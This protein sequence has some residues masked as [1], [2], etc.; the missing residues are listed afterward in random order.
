MKNAFIGIAARSLGSIRIG[1]RAL[2]G[3][4]RVVDGL[5]KVA[6]WIGGNRA[7]TSP[8]SG[9]QFE[10]DLTDRI[11]R[12]MWGNIYELHVRECFGVLLKPGAVFLDVGAHIG[13]HAVF[14]ARRVGPGGSVIAFEA[15][16]GIHARLTRNLAQF[17]W[18][19]AVNAAVW[20]QSG[21]LMFERSSVADES[22]WGSVTA[23][24]RFGKGENLR[25]QSVS[26]DDWSRDVKV[27]RCEM[28]KL[29]AEGSELAILRGASSFLEEFRPILILEINK[30]VLEQGGSSSGSLSDFLLQRRYHLF[31]LEYQCLRPW[32]CLDQPDLCDALC[33]PE[34][35]SSEIL[36]LL[37]RRG[38]TFD[39][40]DP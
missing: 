11:Q 25:I 18:A 22:G 36:S 10:T 17:Q 38:F 8:W 2:P 6:R 24:R 21:T 12:Q 28:M 9:V 14:A 3:Q 13:F 4:G 32:N 40:A 27:G 33:L 19:K 23:V 31:R 34:E 35:R 7:V 20:E 39:Q 30:V 16:P 5:G 29:D 1:G 37:S 26:L 15:D